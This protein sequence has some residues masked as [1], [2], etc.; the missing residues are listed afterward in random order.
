MPSRKDLKKQK[1]KTSQALIQAALQLCAEEGYASLSLRSVARK[2]GIAPT[3][4]YR[5]F[6]E[7]DEMGVAMV[8]QAKEVMDNCL[9]QARKKMTFPAIKK[10][11]S[12]AHLLKSIECMTRPFAETF[13]NFLKKNNQLLHLFFQERT[14]SSE[15][16]RKAIFD[17]TDQL[18]ELLA[19]D[20]KQL[21]ESSKN[22]LGDVRLISETMLTIVSSSGMEMLVHPKAKPG[23][24]TGDITGRAI[25]KLNLLLLGAL[26]Y[27]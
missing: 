13:I 1:E 16:M 19:E 21:S 26:I 9:A 25:Q 24:I 22:K 11:D 7:I 20:L 23:D 8:A 15:A 2:A 12:P 17:A 18:T 4:F 14:G 10:S 5:H 27:E 6:R 3:S